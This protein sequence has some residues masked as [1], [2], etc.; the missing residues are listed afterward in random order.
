MRTAASARTACR[1]STENEIPN[2]EK[3]L[4]KWAAVR[5][6][7]SAVVCVPLTIS[8][9]IGCVQQQLNHDEDGWCRQ[10]QLQMREPRAH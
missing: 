3:L 9:H 1:K 7:I 10:L 4:E 2:T 8:L 5:P 6:R